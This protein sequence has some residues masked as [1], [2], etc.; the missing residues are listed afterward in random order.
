MSDD[1]FADDLDSIMAD[2]ALHSGA[3]L[4]IGGNEYPCE[5]G[6][7]SLAVSPDLTGDAPDASATVFVLVK[8][9]GIGSQPEKGQRVTYDEKNWT[10]AA[11]QKSVDG[12]ELELT[13]SKVLR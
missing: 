12:L 3:T 7:P 5:P 13:L 10:I 1:L 8:D 6:Q 4:S 9:F 2:A 11:V